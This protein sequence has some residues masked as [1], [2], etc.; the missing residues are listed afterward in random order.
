MKK[1]FG[2]ITHITFI[3]NIAYGEFFPAYGQHYYHNNDLSAPF[4]CQN[5][6]NRN[7]KKQLKYTG[8][9]NSKINVF[10]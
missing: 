9:D 8:N 2:K 3:H 7:Q 6:K 10:I 1:L 4:S 5:P